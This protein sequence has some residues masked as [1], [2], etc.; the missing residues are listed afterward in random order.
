ML[1]NIDKPM[2]TA[3]L[4]NDGCRYIPSP[5]GTEFKPVDKLG[6]DGG[7]FPVNSQ[8]E[9]EQIAVREF[10]RAKFSLCQICSVDPLAAGA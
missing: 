2:L 6:R 10:D 3:I 9:A 7:W 8:V 5:Y 1:L 4:H